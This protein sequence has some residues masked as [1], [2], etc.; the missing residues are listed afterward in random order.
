MSMTQSTRTSGS[1]SVL[2]AP[3]A[4]EMLRPKNGHL[5]LHSLIYG[6]DVECELPLKRHNIEDTV[7]SQP[8]ELSLWPLHIKE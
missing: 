8:A 3:T 1:A 5:C 2:E 6:D 7:E 4:T